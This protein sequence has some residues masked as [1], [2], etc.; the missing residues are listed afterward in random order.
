MA[1]V[2]VIDDV[3]G[4][5]RSVVSILRRAGHEVDEADN[6]AQGIRMAG[7]RR[8]DLV[9]TDILMPEADGSE[10]ITALRALPV[11]PKLIA[12]SGG[13]SLV[14]TEDALVYARHA[15]DA[16]IQKPFEAEEILAL[17]D[18]LVGERAA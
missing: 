6:G 8:Y 4:V 7:E 10:V 1:R 3:R 14:R 15:A 11:R 16:A 2:L 12:M 5:R 9:I 17:V 13:G 18:R